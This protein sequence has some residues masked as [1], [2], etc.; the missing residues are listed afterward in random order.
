MSPSQPASPNGQAPETMVNAKGRR[1]VSARGISWILRQA[2]VD[3]FLARQSSEDIAEELGLPV[4]TVT[5]VLLLHTLRKGP[6][7][8]TRAVLAQRRSA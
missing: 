2:I 7:T 5:D 3:S 6:H 8:E 4:R 1:R